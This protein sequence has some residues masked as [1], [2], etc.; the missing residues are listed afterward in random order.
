MKN[1]V[2]DIET[3]GLE[4]ESFD[5]SI[6]DYFIKRHES[7]ENAK[8]LLGLS[9]I[10]GKIIVISMLDI[11]NKKIYTFMDKQETS[12]FSNEEEVVVDNYKV[13]Y[14][15][16]DER[17]IL[18][19]FWNTIK[20]YDRFI[21]YNGRSFDIPFIVA[22]SIYHR[23]NPTKNILTN[24][25]YKNEHFD[26]YDQLTGYNATRGYSLEMWCKT[27]GIT[28]PKEKGIDGSKVGDYYKKGLIK[29]IADYCNRDVIATAE[30][31][32]RIKPFYN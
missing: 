20:N 13:K 21:T 17:G 27:F 6:K 1:I 10:T 29:E 16:S 19:N 14:I 25:Y 28:N 8:E 9:P 18:H 32:E 4:W 26:I 12:L 7:E 2:F 3:A 5:K 15:S 31:F 11:E 30:L 24:R 22:R 23:L